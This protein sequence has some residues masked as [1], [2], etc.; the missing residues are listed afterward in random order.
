MSDG[1]YPGALRCNACGDFHSGDCRD[2]RERHIAAL[3]G[4]L[5]SERD[6]GRINDEVLRTMLHGLDLEEATLNRT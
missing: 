3:Q 5:A 4:E 6:A 1:P 2:P